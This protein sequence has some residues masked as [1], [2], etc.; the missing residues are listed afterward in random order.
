MNL[1]VCLHLVK[2]RSGILLPG[3]VSERHFWLLI[4][5]SG[6]HSEKVINALREHLVMGYTR[7][8]ACEQHGVS[9][10][11][12]SGA[13]VRIQHLSQTVNNL[14]PYYVSGLAMNHEE[15]GD[16]SVKRGG[17]WRV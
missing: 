3:E 11:Y 6:M 1:E 7:R 8:E 4:E 17:D 15:E 10:G 14:L 9:Q 2:E 12:L 16:R 13:L 5:I